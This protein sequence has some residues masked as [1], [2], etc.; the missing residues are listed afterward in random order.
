MAAITRQDSI[1][2]LGPTII[3]DI[4]MM[5][6]IDETENEMGLTN[7]KTNK[8]PWSQIEDTALVGL[9]D[10]LGVVGSW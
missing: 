3:P 1:V 7:L 9:I 5:D 2:L 4:P 6:T 10:Q 8:R